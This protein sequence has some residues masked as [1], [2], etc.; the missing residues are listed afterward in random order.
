MDVPK[1]KLSEQLGIELGEVSADR[2]IAH[3]DVDESHHQPYG[4]MHGGVSLVLAESVASI[5]ANV[6]APEGKQAVGLEI[7]ANH[8]RK[9]R[10]DTLTAEAEPIHRGSSTQVW[11]IEITNSDGEIVCESR[12]TVSNVDAD[13]SNLELRD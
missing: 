5:G 1:G 2:V 6:A 11:S 9:V 4:I 10:N 13:R 3:I 7:N 8:I 12:C